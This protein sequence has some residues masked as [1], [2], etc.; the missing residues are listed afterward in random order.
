MG[1][2]VECALRGWEMSVV[3]CEGER[4]CGEIMDGGGMWFLLRE[5]WGR[6][7][8]CVGCGGSLCDG[9]QS[10]I[11]VNLHLPSSSFSSSSKATHTFTP[12]LPL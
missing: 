5:V 6:E 10:D 1:L 4:E 11:S 2:R 12:S 7:C 8:V 9:V 3:F